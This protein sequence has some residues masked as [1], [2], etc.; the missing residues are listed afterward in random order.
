MLKGK[1]EKK[2]NTLSSLLQAIV[3]NKCS[4][5]NQT[6]AVG[7]VKIFCPSIASYIPALNKFPPL[8]NTE[9]AE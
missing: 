7:Y 3:K 6:L 5:Q 8:R 2:K 9:P 1:R 4:L